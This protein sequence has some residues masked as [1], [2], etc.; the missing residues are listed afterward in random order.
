V[1]QVSLDCFWV[2]DSDAARIFVAPVYQHRLR[3]TMRIENRLDDVGDSDVK[4]SMT[5]CNPYTIFVVVDLS[6]RFALDMLP[7][8]LSARSNSDIDSRFLYSLY[9]VPTIRVVRRV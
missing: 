1:L 5:N 6:S 7:F 4:L 2:I 9:Q 8:H 3:L